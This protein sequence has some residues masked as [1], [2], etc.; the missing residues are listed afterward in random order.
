MK[1]INIL[2][3][4]VAGT[5]VSCSKKESFPETYGVYSG[6]DGEYEKLT[7][8]STKPVDTKTQ[9]IVFDH[10]VASG[11]SSPDQL[12]RLLPRRYVRKNVEHVCPSRNAAPI[13]IRV[14]Q[15][16]EF[17]AFGNALSL[18]FAPVEDKQGMIRVIP[19]SSI[20][21]G[22]YYLEFGGSRYPITVGVSVD[23]QS[24]D[25]FAIDAHHTTIDRDA[26]FSWDN[27]RT[28]TQRGLDQQRSIGGN[29]VIKTEYKSP[30][31]LQSLKAQFERDAL[32]A[33]ER[34][35]Y[36]AAIPKIESV[37]S[38]DPS[39]ETLRTTLSK[40][41]NHE[42][43]SAFESSDWAASVIYIDTALAIDPSLKSAMPSREQAVAALSQQGAPN[44][45]LEDS[46]RPTKNL[47]ESQDAEQVR[48]VPSDAV[49]KAFRLTDTGLAG[50]FTGGFERG[51]N[52][53]TLWFGELTGIESTEATAKL[54]FL[55]YSD[56][57]P[58]IRVGKAGSGDWLLVFVSSTRR[59]QCMKLIE[60]AYRT[61]MDTVTVG[62]VSASADVPGKVTYKIKALPRAW[63]PPVKFS[64]RLS[65]K[66]VKRSYG[67]SIRNASTKQL[68][69]TDGRSLP[70]GVDLQFMSPARYESNI[71]LI[72]TLP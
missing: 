45:T 50:T 21:K 57:R 4:C 16:G 54:R 63:S 23:A 66:A 38:I 13:R 9:F 27:W 71:E 31:V 67:F 58:A 12:V 70:T 28:I 39:D 29:A 6:K 14:S 55:K 52:E 43:N 34:L 42:A 61:W 48:A 47:W 19:S 35:D 72:A 32:A 3:L 46:K 15:A 68:I 22:L 69:T 24:S 62:S 64:P 44:R 30:Q 59:D 18:S 40:K 8:G 5:L 17:G 37:E 53:Y 10:Q 1:S 7:E 65:L 49:S 36:A 26:S 60:Q 41:L 11:L 33:I 20:P 2:Y 51:E 25:E 56:P